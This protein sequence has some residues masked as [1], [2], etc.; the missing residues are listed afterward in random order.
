MGAEESKPQPPPPTAKELK[1]KMT[2][3]IDKMIREFNKDKFKLKAEAKKIERDLEK[4][5]KNKEPRSSQKIIAMNL[6]KN[7]QFMAKYDMMEA[8]MKGVKIQIQQ[9]ATTEAMVGIMKGM[10]DLLGHA[11]AQVD[12]G[13]IQG[14]IQDFNMKMEEQEGLNE[15]LEDAFEDEEEIEDEAVDDLID[16]VTNKVNGGKGGGKNLVD[17]DKEENFSGMIDDLKK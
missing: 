7:R 5:V 2:R 1:K 15:M 4:M 9:V 6:M 16:N 13:N 17:N 10:G 11:T 8:K 12:M 3:S 14:V